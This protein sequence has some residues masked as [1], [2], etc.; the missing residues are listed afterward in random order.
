MQR[1]TLT[2]AGLV[3]AVST[4]VHAAGVYVPTAT[5]TEFHHIPGDNPDE[6]YVVLPEVDLDVAPASTGPDA[7]PGTPDVLQQSVDEQ[8]TPQPTQQTAAA[9]APVR[10]HDITSDIEYG[11]LR[12]TSFGSTSKGASFALKT[13]YTRFIGYYTRVGGRL[14]YEHTTGDFNG[15]YPNTMPGNNLTS[16]FFFKRDVFAHQEAGVHMNYSVFFDADMG[17]RHTFNPQ[18]YY[19]YKRTVGPVFAF[20]GGFAGYSITHKNLD[21]NPYSDPETEHTFAYSILAG[22][23]MS[24]GQRLSANLESYISHHFLVLGAHVPVF[25]SE[26]FMLT[27][28]FKWPIMFGIDKYTNIKLTVGAHARL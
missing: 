1:F 5:G 24:V 15:D 27:P 12:H 18:V 11:L 13:Q 20:G 2:V 8:T 14:Y 17:P 6:T 9:Q 19:V 4:V 25:V 26:H 28:G 16:V 23:G 21:H 22:G 7:G 3:F 10:V